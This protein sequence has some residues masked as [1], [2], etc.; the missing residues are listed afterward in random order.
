VSLSLRQRVLL[1]I[2]AINVAVVG[3][4]VL[5]LARGLVTSSTSAAERQARDLVGLLRGQI[6]PE[7]EVNAVH[8]LRWPKWEGLADALLVDRRLDETASGR[9][10]PSGVALNPM[11]AAHRP[12]DFD[13]QGV[14]RAIRLALRSNTPVEGV[15]GGRVIPID[16]D[17]GVWGGLW[18][19]FEPQIDAGA[20]L[21]RYFLPIFA[22][23]TLL[24]SAVTF[25]GLERFVLDP[26]ARLASGA[27]RIAHGDLSVHVA[28]P[29]RRDELAEL[30]RAFNAMTVEVRDAEQRLARE[31]REATAQARRAEAAAMTQRRLAATG[32][33][34]AGIAHEINNPL[35]GLQNAAL[36]LARGDLSEKKRE[37]YLELLLSGLERIRATVG[38]LLRFTPRRPSTAPLR[39]ERPVADALALVRHRA[40]AE[41]VEL[42]LAAGGERAA[43]T[44]G[45]WP[46]RLAERLSGLPTLYGEEGGLAQALLNLLVNALDALRAPR[47]P[48]SGPPRVE[49]EL[50]LGG[51]EL[52][53]AVSDNG[54]GVD[55]RQMG[56]IGDLFYTTKEVGQGTGLGLPI[57]HN[58]AAA[59]GGRLELE[60]QPG[61]GFRATLILP[62]AP[63][64]GNAADGARGARG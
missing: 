29:P 33:L 4:E 34:A 8:I 53:I 35:G 51:S 59:H 11:G 40:Q 49:V 5:L 47:A 17:G 57:V 16:H 56:R 20:L 26:V 58:V 60:S 31:V 1:L 42:V 39:I 21:L 24:L 15:A 46:P 45:P 23:S 32:E 3:A 22:L 28:E 13:Y 12:A 10:V 55:E 48:G 41:G 64:A 19:R 44:G 6:R 9:L 38:Q 14:Y 7:A 2:V 36:A 50:S 27:R 62:L 52:S 61:A 30:V 63:P 25:F 37:Q 18:Y 43:V 54:P